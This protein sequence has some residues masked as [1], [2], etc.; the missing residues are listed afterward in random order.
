MTEKELYVLREIFVQLGKFVQ[1]YGK[2]YYNIQIKA[3]SDIIKCIDSMASEKEKTEYILDKYKILYPSKGG[4]NDFY[5]HDDDFHTRLKL[6][7]PL[8]AL[9]DKLWMIMKQYI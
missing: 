6:N 8:D 9:K 1:E 7:E 4:L 2:K 3:I 5:I